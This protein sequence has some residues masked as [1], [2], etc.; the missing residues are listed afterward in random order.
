MSDALHIA[1]TLTWRGWGALLAAVAGLSFLAVVI[2]YMRML[3][4]RAKMVCRIL[5]SILNLP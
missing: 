1:N 3:W 5:N 4:L 2:D